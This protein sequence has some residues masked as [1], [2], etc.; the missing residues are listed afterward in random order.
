MN[1][2]NSSNDV[3]KPKPSRTTIQKAAR[4]R[5]D[6]LIES[7]KGFLAGGIAMGV[8]YAVGKKYIPPRFQ[9]NNILVFAFL[10]SAAFGSY[11]GSVTA[12]RN[13]LELELGGM[14]RVVPK[15]EV[16]AI[17]SFKRRQEA[18]GSRKG[19]GSSN[20]S[21]NGSGGGSADGDGGGLWQQPPPKAAA[22]GEESEWAYPPPPISSSVLPPGEGSGRFK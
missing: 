3:D 13:S 15:H 14:Q 5:T 9:H 1:R 18:W 7:T 6:V 11:I 2:Q 4:I 19:A 22:G 8:L 12:A 10:T 21:G 16:V 20:G 17:E